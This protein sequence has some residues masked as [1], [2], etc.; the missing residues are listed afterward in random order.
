MNDDPRELVSAYQRIGIERMQGLP[1]VNPRLQ[2]EA[3]GFR[4]WEE[5]FVGILIAPW[6][7]NLIV[8]PVEPAEKQ[9]P[10]GA[11]IELDLPGGRHEFDLCEVDGVGAHLSLPLFSSVCA[12]PDQDTARGVAEETL[13]VLFAEST[14]S[15]RDAAPTLTRR[16][17]LSG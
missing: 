9:L 5:R 7:L 3:V 2:V 14:E 1:M 13:R 11:K 16:A 8:L 4:C 6:F 12:F 10:N 17:L 15:A